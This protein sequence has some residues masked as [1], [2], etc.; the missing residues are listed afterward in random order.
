M[1][2]KKILNELLKTKEA[3]WL[4]FKSEWYWHDSVSKEIKSEKWGEFLKDFA[5][6]FNIL[7]EK[8][9]YLVIG[10]D[11]E[12][13][14]KKPIQ[15]ISDLQNIEKLKF[16]IVEKIKNSFAFIKSL[17]EEEPDL[18]SLFQIDWASD[19][20]VISITQ[21]L[22]LLELRRELKG[23]S[24]KV[25][26]KGSVFTRYLDKQ[27]SPYIDTMSHSEIASV[28][29]NLCS[30]NFKNKNI[31]SIQKIVEAYRD[32]QI[33]KATI[34]PR[35][36]TK[37]FRYQFY[38]IVNRRLGIHINFVY[39]SSSSSQKRAINELLEKGYLKEGKNYILT[40]RKNTS[41]ELV[42]KDTIERMFHNQDKSIKIEIFYINEFIV[43][44]LCGDIFQSDIFNDNSFGINAFVPP[45]VINQEKNV[46]ILMHEWL[47]ETE[48][49][50]LLI[51]GAGGIGKTTVVKYFLDSVRK[52]NNTYKHTLFISSNEIVKAFKRSERIENISNLF[53]F[54]NFFIKEYD[55]DDKY[56]FTQ[57]AFDVVVG[58]GNL[59]IVLDGIDEVISS[60]GNRFNILEFLESIK[61]NC[62]EFFKTKIIIT[63]RDYFWEDDN[64]FENLIET[65]F[66]QEF[67]I[68]QVEK[69]FNN[70]LENP[71]DRK[72]A[73]KQAKEWALDKDENRFVPY[74]LDMIQTNIKL[75]QLF[76]QPLSNNS[77]TMFSKY[78]AKDIK[79]DNIIRQVCERETKKMKTFKELESGIDD[80]ND[81]IDKQIEVF[82]EM[83]VLYDG[84]LAERNFTSILEGKSIPL[85]IID[86][87]KAHP[88]ICFN[89]GLISFKYDFFDTLFKNI[90]V[91]RKL[92]ETNFDDMDNKIS[93]VISQL[94]AYENDFAQ[95]VKKRLINYSK[96][97]EK[98]FAK[99]EERFFLWIQ[100][101]DKQN[102]MEDNCRKISS[103]IFSLLIMMLCNNNVEDRTSLLKKLYGQKENGKDVV[104]NLHLINIHSPNNQ[105]RLSFD[106]S[107]IIFEDCSFENYEHFIKNK[108]NEKTLFKHCSFSSPLCTNDFQTSLTH[109]NIDIKTCHTISGIHDVLENQRH[110]TENEEHTTRNGLEYIIKLFYQNGIFKKQLKEKIKKKIGDKKELLDTLLK[111]EVIQEE[112]ESSSKRKGNIHYII[113]K[114]YSNLRKF[115]EE[116]QSGCYEFEEILLL[117]TKKLAR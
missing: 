69:Y 55:I 81:A 30:N 29:Q 83:A 9:K 40:D 18:N 54:Y 101:W 76:K 51:K 15:K 106:F 13:Q 25:Y 62:F 34:E 100:K 1:E 8:T 102:P 117:C 36:T 21:N 45:N 74:I 113:N 47:E 2:I 94:I 32:S 87:F 79:H 97:E 109:K 33:Q 19:L 60:M 35:E 3:K 16:S 6:L 64:R 75:E 38:K 5:A 95:N 37:E 57:E 14:K 56:I 11:E 84:C 28:K 98:L 24:N 85:S 71:N 108:F 17:D 52:E 7:E 103:S 49:P 72:L 53:D 73:I 77:S 63:C 93:Q 65:L 44:E 68:K 22:Y 27:N 86:N 12:T 96:D 4:E 116:N 48:K 39:F 23:N 104:K 114:K 110:K 115:I 91:S 112:S 107:G 31:I 10:F 111:L 59:L 41:K 42:K 105:E 61:N 66:L 20:L 92:K 80:I 46:E 82:I 70:T 50:L 99:I 67:D 26:S 89:N 58:N 90:A 88:L 78:L 43:E